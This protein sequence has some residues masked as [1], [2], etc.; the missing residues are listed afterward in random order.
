MSLL[1]TV[2]CMSAPGGI[3][4]QHDALVAPRDGV[5]RVLLAG[6]LH[7]DLGWAM[8]LVDIAAAL[9]CQVVLQ[10]GDFGALWP[11]D[12]GR[13]ERRL[14]QHLEHA[15]VWLVYVD[16][17]HEGWHRL[18][19]LD[20]RA[21]PD[22]FVAVCPHV[23][24]A[25]RGLRWVWGGVRFGALGGAYSTDR[26][27]RREGR[28][29][30]ASLEAPT[31]DDV[32]RLGNAPLDVLVTHDAPL[33]SPLGSRAITPY[34]EQ[35]ARQVRRLISEAVWRTEPALL[36]HGHWHQRYSY[37]MDHVRP[38]RV[39]GFACNDAARWKLGVPETDSYGLLALPGLEVTGGE[40]LDL[41]SAMVTY[42]VPRRIAR[43][44]RSTIM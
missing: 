1:A 27:H 5:D 13:F 37:Q 24:H 19:T 28:D 14:G 35:C 44:G 21:A 23:L 22:S 39:E 43:M 40:T 36:V 17:N 3:P 11:G 2:L 30:W 26:M 4:L 16:G 18:A 8:T 31:R 38:V 10:L 7:G 15:G 29:L 6:D 9:G 34:D 32:L 12:G 20:S 41:G 25:P 42:R 33:E